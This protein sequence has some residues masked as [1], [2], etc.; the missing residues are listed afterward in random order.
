MWSPVAMGLGLST[1]QFA[2]GHPRRGAPTIDWGFGFVCRG[3]GVSVGATLC[4]RP[5]AMG[6]GL[7]APQFAPGHPRRGAPT[8]DGVLV[9]CLVVTVF[10]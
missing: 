3:N 7:S 8:N 6:L 1:P 5:W 2:P 4:G 9:L 10:L